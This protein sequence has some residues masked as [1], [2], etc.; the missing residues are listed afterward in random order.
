M[1]MAVGVALPFFAVLMCGFLARRLRILDDYGVRGLNAFVYWFAL[2]AKAAALV[3]RILGR[4][5]PATECEQQRRA[6]VAAETDRCFD[7]VPLDEL[8]TAV[9][10]NDPHGL[11]EAINRV[12]RALLRNASPLTSPE[13]SQGSE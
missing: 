4:D 2:P 12:C 3:A 8:G 6:D 7:Q 10:G 5:A 1:E 11:G 13:S 9:A